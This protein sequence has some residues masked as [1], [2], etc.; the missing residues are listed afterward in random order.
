MRALALGLTPRHGL[1]GGLQLL[2]RGCLD[3]NLAARL[4]AARSDAAS[5]FTEQTLLA[6]LMPKAA[7]PLPP[8]RYVIS[9]RRQFY[10]ETDVDYDAIAIR[11][12]TGPVRHV[13]YLSGLPRLE[14]EARG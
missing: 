8:E 11:H 5:W 13:M 3:L 12:F 9:T 1:N 6:L 10:W 7:E 14:R 4:L 2:S